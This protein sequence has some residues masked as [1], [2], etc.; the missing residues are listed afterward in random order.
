MDN[1]PGSVQSGRSLATAL[2]DGALARG[3][4]HRPALVVDDDTSPSISGVVAA[5]DQTVAVVLDLVQPAL[6]GW[7]RSA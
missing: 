5:G 6:S 2:Y 4:E 7:G 3:L 1:G